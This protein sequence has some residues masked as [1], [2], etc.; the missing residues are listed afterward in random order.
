VLQDVGPATLNAIAWL[1]RG[2]GGPV[3]L[4]LNLALGD[5]A[6]AATL[7]AQARRRL[8]RGAL[9][10]LEIGNEPDL[11]RHGHTF[12]SGGHVHRRLIK[13]P[14][15]GLATYARAV[16]RYLRTL[17]QP[18]GPRLVVGGFAGPAWGRSLPQL[19]AGW[20]GGPG[21]LAAHLYALP[22]CKA[23]TPSAD[24]LMSQ[25]ASRDR[26]A[27]LTPLMTIARRS[28]LPLRVSELNSAACGG[29]PHLSDSPA[30][31]L[32]LTDTLFWILR[33]G[34][35]GADVHTW[36]GASYAPFAI[37]AGHVVPRPPLEGMLAFAKA[38][39]AG[40]R[41]VGVTVD[42]GNDELRA[43]A[44]RDAHHVIR[45][46]LLAPDAAHVAIAS[47]GRTA[48]ATVWRSPAQRRRAACTR[49]SARRYAISLPPRSMA[50][51]TLP[52]RRSPTSA[53]AP[54]SDLR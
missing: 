54:G 22:L 53:T 30:A 2:L 38:A 51:I 48:C 14:H 6:N 43:W 46:A 25:A 42:A 4:G 27:S 50:V 29:R 18:A 40:S 21:A 16:G 17:A 3:T 5:P 20:R 34:A 9:D 28:G 26:V 47:G 12:T 52:P 24:W 39:P 32:W 35:D 41:L 36:R 19:L 7:A 44:T 49:A 8:P 10:A 23:P 33:L 31:A 15:Y 11:Y 1:A 45:L 37:G 13:D